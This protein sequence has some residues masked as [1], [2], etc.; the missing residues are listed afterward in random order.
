L[1]NDGL[2]AP[3][4]GELSS[5][6]RKFRRQ[7]SSGSGQSSLS[8]RWGQAQEP[9]LQRARAFFRAAETNESHSLSVSKIE[10]MRHFDVAGMQRVVAICRWGSSGSLLLASYL[11]GHDDVIM[12]P[13]NLSGGIYPFFECYQSLSLRDKLIAYPFVSI[14]G[15]DHSKLFFQ[16]EHENGISA[17]D[18]YAAV[19][20]LFEVYGHRPREFLESRRAFFQFLH[21]VYC[22]GL[23]RRPA[24]PQPLIV[25]AQAMANDQLA[26]YLVEDFPQARF[27]HTVRDPITNCGRLFEH[28]LQAHGSL[29]AMYVIARL[30]FWDKPHSGM[31]SRTLAVRFED[32]HLHLE[33]TMGAVAAWLGLAY[34]PSLLEST[35][36]GLQYVWKPRTGAAGWSGARPE[37]AVRDSRNLFFTDRCLLFAVLYED[38]VAWN[39]PCPRIFRHAWVRV[40]TC[41][42]LLPVP[43]KIE[44]ITAR[45]VFKLLPSKNFSR[46]I[47]GLARICIGRVA[48]MSL[49]A[50]ELYRRLVFG[51]QV[52]E[53]R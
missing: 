42:L 7:L 37:K 17:A 43:T 27:I 31:E 4:A 52:L 26:R 41:L 3:S 36:N 24:S 47:K 45:M 35:F 33:E 44:I 48:I 13:G 15:Y 9:L 1:Q 51:K 40:L 50:V 39:Y 38:F 16:T 23:G 5:A 32:L 29:A 8:P 34:R 10:N 53:L 20:A 49:L 6:F 14:D 25:Y 30:S 28:D 2:S 11:D 18:Y 46:A 21:I 19:N 12:L 22:V